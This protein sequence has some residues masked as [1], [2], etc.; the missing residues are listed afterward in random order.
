MSKRQVDTN[1]RDE[2]ASFDS[3]LCPGILLSAL[4]FPA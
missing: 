2:K 1:K 3:V 4:A